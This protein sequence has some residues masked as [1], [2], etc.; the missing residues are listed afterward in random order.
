L[1]EQNNEYRNKVKGRIELMQAWL[2]GKQVQYKDLARN[3]IDI[4]EPSWSSMY[5]YRIKPENK[6][7]YIGIDK[8]EVTGLDTKVD[9]LMGSEGV[10]EL[11]FDSNNKLEA[12]RIVK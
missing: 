8:S 12:I 9:R 10:V 4:D 3:W 7:F 5:E 6:K 1:N 2:D 11:S